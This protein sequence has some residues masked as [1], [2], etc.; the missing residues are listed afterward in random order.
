MGQE[1]YKGKGGGVM[2]A[3]AKITSHMEDDPTDIWIVKDK[4]YD[5]ILNTF[6][7]EYYFIDEQGDSHSIDKKDFDKY[8]KV[9]D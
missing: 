3:I 2:K 9:V 6:E 7:D 4:E 5:L 1:K 8:F